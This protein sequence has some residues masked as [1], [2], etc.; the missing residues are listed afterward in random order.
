MNIIGIDLGASKIEIV[1][2][3]NK[4]NNI[5]YRRRFL[6]EKKSYSDLLNQIEHI[7]DSSPLSGKNTKIGLGAPGIID[8]N[9][10][11]IK[12]SSIKILDNK[13]FQKDLNKKLKIPVKVLNDA[14]CFALSEAVFGAGKDYKMVVG[15][16][17]GT[18]MGGG[19]IYDGKIMKGKNG[20]AGE[21]GHIS[22]NENGPACY[23][24]Q[25]GCQELFLSGSGIQ[26]IYKEKTG[27]DKDVKKI[28]KDSIRKKDIASMETMRIFM[29]KFKLSILNI[30]LNIDPDIIV[31]G[32]GVSNLPI[33]FEKSNNI[34]QFKFF[35]ESLKIP[36]VKNLLGDSSGVIGAALAGETT[37]NL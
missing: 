33:F 9:S 14:N 36:V 34:L 13:N 1:V 11:Y 4:P 30:I 19:I 18:G 26:R 23:C 28:Y 17:L 15:V 24:G 31:L 10:G 35:K 20:L 27:Q 29:R 8:Q 16:I 12:F 22:F 3:K 6:T 2:T 5:I 25:R 7:I 21:W 32:G 37:K